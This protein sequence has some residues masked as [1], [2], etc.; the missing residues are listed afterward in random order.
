MWKSK[1]KTDRNPGLCGHYQSELD[2]S[3]IPRP[4]RRGKITFPPSTWPELRSKNIGQGAALEQNDWAHV[5]G[6]TLWDDYELAGMD[7]YECHLASI[8]KH[9]TKL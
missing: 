8:V 1:R 5:A 3:L 7:V 4:H 6:L 9:V 2:N